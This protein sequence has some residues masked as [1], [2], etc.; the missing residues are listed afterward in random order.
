MK[1]ILSVDIFRGITL[2][3]MILVNTQSGGGFSCL[4]HISG[5]GWTLADLVY[6][7][8]I[9][10]VGASTYLSMRKYDG[11]SDNKVITRILKRTLY[12]F[13]F[14]IL[15]NWIPFTQNLLDVRIMG[16]LQRIA[17]AY[18]ACSLI[19]LR[20]KGVTALLSISGAILVGYWILTYIFGYECVDNVDLAIIGSKHLYTPTHDPQGL[21]SSIPA[22][23]N[24]LIGYVAARMLMENTP[25]KGLKMLFI[26]G[27]SLFIVS[28][29]LDYTILPIY[30]SYWS[31]SFGLLTI[32]LASLT[33]CVVHLISDVYEY[34]RWGFFFV[35]LG[36]NSILCYMLSEVVAVFFWEWGIAKYIVEFYGTFMN[37]AF[38]SISWGLTVVI[39]CFLVVLP[40]YKRKIFLRL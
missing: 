19:T 37:P 5:P 11:I 2:F 36:T 14:G 4:I 38:T 23:V 39:I 7:F 30:R 21:L 1:R 20:V 32:G 3:L 28:Q 15:Y 34:K 10:I 31:S 26:L 40:L 35:V 12:I 17:L 29:I 25:E 18:M 9:F 22:I 16:V 6:P 33:W 8:F 27:L 13:L 24:A